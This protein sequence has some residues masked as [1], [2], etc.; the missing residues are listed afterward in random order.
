MRFHTWVV[1]CTLTKQ[2]C[3]GIVKQ[4]NKG[5]STNHSEET[6][7]YTYTS[8]VVKICIRKPSTF[9]WSHLIEGLK[10][11]TG[12]ESFYTV[13]VCASTGINRNIWVKEIESSSS[14]YDCWRLKAR[15]TA[16]V[17]LMIMWL[18]KWKLSRMTINLGSLV[19]ADQNPPTLRLNTFVSR[20]KPIRMPQPRSRK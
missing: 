18:F 6:E 7:L 2:I 12:S 1:H 11:L 19:F 14:L 17:V 20:V 15:K 13:T 10:R 9:I 4:S 16:F 5:S 8:C 3:T